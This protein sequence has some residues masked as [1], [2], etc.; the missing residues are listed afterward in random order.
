MLLCSTLIR[1]TLG[2]CKV[3]APVVVALAEP[4]PS[5]DGEATAREEELLRKL[6]TKKLGGMSDDD[7]VSTSAD[8][9]A[10]LEQINQMREG[11]SM[12]Q[13]LPP[14]GAEDWGRW[15]QDE[16]GV[17]LELFVGAE[18]VAKDVECA[19]SVGFLDVRIKDDPLLSGRL[20]QPVVIG[21]LNWAL[22][23]DSALRDQ[24]LL[25]IDMP[26]RERAI[27]GDG[28]SF[29]EPLFESL[30]VHGEEIVG[31]GLVAGRYLD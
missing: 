18:V 8:L 14:R 20:A 19:I 4:V 23:D 27:Y 29:T 13:Q 17:S 22:D 31:P 9:E 1:P 24:R 21:D 25:C 28:A 12:P 26:K 15:S 7:I 30:R 3:R 5:G 6:M 16:D 11:F 2:Q 10:D